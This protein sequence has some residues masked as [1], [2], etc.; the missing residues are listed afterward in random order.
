[1]SAPARVK[2][3][4][5]PCA[6][7]PSGCLCCLGSTPSAAGVGV[8]VA[9][10]GASGRGSEWA[11]RAIMAA[12]GYLGE[13]GGDLDGCRASVDGPEP[14]TARVWPSAS[15]DS[16]IR[17]DDRNSKFPHLAIT[18]HPLLIMFGLEYLACWRRSNNRSNLYMLFR[19]LSRFFCCFVLKILCQP[20]DVF[21]RKMLKEPFWKQ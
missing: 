8:A 21:F 2:R 9:V 17:G 1:M 20:F 15:A 5:R 10:Q 14:R 12:G 18:R 19:R 7:T 3:R 6:A 4:A 11:Q 16:A 13:N